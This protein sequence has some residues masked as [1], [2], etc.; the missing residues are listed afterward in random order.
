MNK[1]DEKLACCNSHPIF[2]LIAMLG[3]PLLVLGSISTYDYMNLEYGLC[4]TTGY[5]IVAQHCGSSDGNNYP[6]A[7]YINFTYSVAGAIY[8]AQYKSVCGNYKESTL[9]KVKRVSFAPIGKIWDCWHWKTDPTYW[10]FSNALT[11]VYLMIVGIAME[12]I[13]LCWGI[14]LIILLC[15]SKYVSNKKHLLM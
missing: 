9:N 1:Y 10:T 8:N 5:T 6:W 14:Y 3:I 15:C 12:A 13:V 4:M 7:G 11:G 2:L